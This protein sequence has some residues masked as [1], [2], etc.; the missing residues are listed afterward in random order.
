MIKRV[1]LLFLLF[2]MLLFG[3]AKE[4]RVIRMEVT[5]YCGCGD[6]CGWERGNPKYLRLDFWN[7]YINY[8]GKKGTKYTG[9]T[10]SGTK[11]HEPR[12]GLFSWDS[13]KHPWMIPIRII[14]PWLIFSRDGTVAAD[15]RYYPFG[16]RMHIP[17]Y[18]FGVVEDRGGAIKGP[19]RLDV[20]FNSH[21]EA[22]RW[23]RQRLSVEIVK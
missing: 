20:F 17:G 3:C 4:P 1:V 11:P 22:L 23:G 18:G 8:G 9:R 14:F 5:A 19:R 13:L 12:P 16:T 15:T 7:K 6:C 10:S 21:R 2:C